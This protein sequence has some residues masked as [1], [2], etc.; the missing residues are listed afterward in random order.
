MILLKDMAQR[1][2]EEELEQ[3]N[4]I[5]CLESEGS[6]KPEIQNAIP[7]LKMRP[8]LMKEMR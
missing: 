4:L 2:K 3:R 1:I 5:E 6:S 7:L 8:H